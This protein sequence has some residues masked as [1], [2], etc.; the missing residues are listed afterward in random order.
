MTTIIILDLYHYLLHYVD[1]LNY[2]YR[3]LRNH[4]TARDVRTDAVTPIL[5]IVVNA[6]PS[7]AQS[8]DFVVTAMALD[9]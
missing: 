2:D 1:F 3:I 8:R 7:V 6:L 5:V 4:A 9:T